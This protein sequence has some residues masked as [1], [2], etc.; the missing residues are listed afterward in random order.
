MTDIHQSHILGGIFFGAYIG[1]RVAGLL[2][3]IARN[4][5][6]KITLCTIIKLI[7]SQVI[8]LTDHYCSLSLAFGSNKQLRSV[9]ILLRPR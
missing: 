8:V 2:D 3:Q 9:G 6:A 5:A 1:I 7:S 4:G